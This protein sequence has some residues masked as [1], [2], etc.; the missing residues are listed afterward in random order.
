MSRPLQREPARAAP[1]LLVL[2]AAL[3]ERSDLSDAETVNLRRRVRVRLEV[4]R[5]RLRVDKHRLE[6]Q[7]ARDSRRSQAQHSAGAGSL[8]A[9]F[10]GQ[11]A[12]IAS[13]QALIDLITQAIEPQTWQVNGGRGTIR[14]FA[15]GR[16]LVVRNTLRVHEQIG[17][18]LAQ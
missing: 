9:A 8:T 18:A 16:V 10:P 12:E 7:A 14:Y 3:H 15:P 6:Q 17:G 1:D 5:D 11:A 13:A 2:Y 4:L